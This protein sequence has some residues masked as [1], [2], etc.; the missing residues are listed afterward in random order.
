MANYTPVEANQSLLHDPH[1]PECELHWMSDRPDPAADCPR[2]GR[3]KS[4]GS[5]DEARAEGGGA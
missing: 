5:A 3:D 2:C 4:A 1:D